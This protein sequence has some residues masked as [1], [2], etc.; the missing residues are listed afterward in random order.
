METL[1][2]LSDDERSPV[3][4]G[5]GFW[6][7]AL[8]RVIDT[9]LHFAIG[10]AAGM[11]AGI[12]VAIGSAIQGVTADATFAKLSET[13]PV[14]FIASVIGSMAMHVLAEGLHGSTVGKRICGLTVISEDGTPATL[15]GA[16]KRDIAY[17]FDALFFGVVAAR[18]MAESPRR[19]RFGDVWGNT[20]VVRLSSLDAGAR[21]S[22]V[23]FVLANAVGI[24]VDGVALFTGLV[25]NLL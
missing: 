10:M 20:Q 13:T 2:D 15:L 24:A 8:A 16:L 22:W 3:R 21:R 23:R 14:T 1:L 6:L 9:L 18:K 19:Q 4:E 7:R 25:S 12:L 17:F 11:T 5:A